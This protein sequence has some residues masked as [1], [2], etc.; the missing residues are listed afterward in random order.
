LGKKVDCGIVWREH[1]TI[2]AFLHAKYGSFFV[3]SLSNWQKSVSW[4]VWASFSVLEDPNTAFSC[5]LEPELVW[6]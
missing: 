2:W 6:N 5:C 3:G 1:A 4:K